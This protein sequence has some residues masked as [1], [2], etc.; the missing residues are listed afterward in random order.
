MA[1]RIFT[2]QDRGGISDEAWR[3]LPKVPPWR[4]RDV[5]VSRFV[6]TDDLLDAVNAA[7]HLRRPLLLTGAPGSGKSTLINLI[8]QE[9]SLGE[10]LKWHITSRSV[11]DDGLF[12]YDALGR[13]HATQIKKTVI[14][15]EKY[16][17]LGPLGTA[18]ASRDK[19][20]AVLID[21]IDKSDFD[22]PSDLLNVLEEGEFDIPPLVRE[23]RAGANGKSK[24]RQTVRGHDRETYDVK[25]GVV[26]RTHWPIIIMTSNGER[27]FPAPFLRRCVRFEMATPELTFLQDV[28]D[29]YLDSVD[30][31]DR[32]KIAEFRQR[33]VAGERLAIDQL[34]NYL[35]LV[36]ADHG[37]TAD[38]RQ[39]LE[40]A[41]LE[42][43]SGR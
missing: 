27:T 3:N 43:L 24:V 33:L 38:T 31:D 4:V 7:L 20:R 18:L 36:T 42:E 10:P 1:W 37:I 13:L 21:E 2:G 32:A 12:H 6:L 25:G 8:A 23:A 22:L 40:K 41:L 35:Y 29:G 5:A 11:L 15:V 14:K 26:R 19:P 9:L 34:L 30:G 17:T 28:V 16:V 39:R